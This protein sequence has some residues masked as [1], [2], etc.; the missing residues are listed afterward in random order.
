MKAT[1]EACG[2]GAQ[3]RRCAHRLLTD[4]VVDDPLDDSQVCLALATELGLGV[5]TGS[6]V[7]KQWRASESAASSFNRSVA[8]LSTTSSLGD[9]VALSERLRNNSFELFAA[10]V[11]AQQSAARN[12]RWACLN[13]VMML[14]EYARIARERNVLRAEN[15]RL[16]QCLEQQQD[17]FRSLCLVTQTLA[18]SVAQASNLLSQAEADADYDDEYTDEQQPQPAAVS[19]D[20]SDVFVLP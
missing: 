4:S 3:G 18:R 7:G 20:E 10:H 5:L 17:E 2:G 15:S 19:M 11:V 8:E 6:V 9:F 16:A 1:L 12:N 13:S 14:K